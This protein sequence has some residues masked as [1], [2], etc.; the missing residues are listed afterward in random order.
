LDHDLDPVVRGT[1]PGIQIRTKML[2]I[3]N[4]V[5]NNA[6]LHNC[7][8][9]YSN[10][11][12]TFGHTKVAEQQYTNLKLLLF[13]LLEQLEFPEFLLPEVVLIVE[14]FRLLIPANTNILYS[15]IL[16]K[17]QVTTVYST[18]SCL[19]QK[20]FSLELAPELQISK[21]PDMTFMENISF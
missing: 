12:F 7:N 17:S 14:C 11:T 10:T 9:M 5:L 2:Q 21:K 8:V 3:P 20:Q 13:L 19:E 4:T 15:R 18:K 1:N 16:S 6:K